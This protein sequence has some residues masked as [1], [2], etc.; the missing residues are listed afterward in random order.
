MLI[1]LDV[2]MFVLFVVL[3]VSIIIQ[4]SKNTESVLKIQAYTCIVAL[5]VE[6]ISLVIRFLQSK[7]WFPVL[8]VLVVHSLISVGIIIDAVD[9]GVFKKKEKNKNINVDVV[10]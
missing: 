10:V 4:N 1:A 9:Y 5:S 2:L 3:M 7:Y 6:T 8:V